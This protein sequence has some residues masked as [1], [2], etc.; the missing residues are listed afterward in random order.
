MPRVD[1]AYAAVAGRV[2]VEAIA[3][4]DDDESTLCSSIHCHGN[5]VLLHG[6]DLPRCGNGIL[7]KR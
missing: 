4:L 7:Y 5:G 2:A 1:D 3:A 6:E